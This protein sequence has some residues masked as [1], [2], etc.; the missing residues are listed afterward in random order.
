MKAR[1][2]VLTTRQQPRTTSFSRRKPTALSQRWRGWTFVETLIVI[3]IILILTASVGF[4]AFRYLDQA[5][6]ATARSQIETLALAIN[7]FYFDC[8]GFPSAEQGLAALWEKP[9]A[10][11]GW[12]GPYLAKAVPRDPW[13]RDYLYRTPGPQGLPFEIL[14]YGADGAEGGEGQNADLSSAR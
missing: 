12:N 14:S 2:P 1:N 3:G 5:K 9:A 11:E 4:M 6:T 7:A 8:K 10:V 13:N